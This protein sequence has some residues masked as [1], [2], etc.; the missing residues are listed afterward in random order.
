MTRVAPEPFVGRAAELAKLRDAFTRCRSGEGS[1][2]VVLA[3]AGG[4]KTRLVETFAEE[5]KASGATIA[6]GRSVEDASVGYWPWR[7]VFRRLEIPLSLPDA[8]A[9]AGSDERAAQRLQVA[10]DALTAL[11]SIMQ[12]G[13]IA[14][15]LEDLHWA[16]EPSLHLLRLLAPEIAAMP[17][18]ILATGRDPEPGTPFESTLGSIVGRPAVIVIRLPALTLAEV[19]AYVGEAPEGKRAAWVHSQS[20]G[21]ALYVRELCRLLPSEP[22]GPDD[23]LPP[24]PVEIRAVIAGRLAQLDEP[25][26]AVVRA[27]TVL[28]DE[29]E[30]RLLEAVHGAPVAEAVDAAVRRAILAH[31]PETPGRARFVHGLVRSALYVELPSALRV[32][33]HRRAAEF[34]EREG[35][36]EREEQAGA[37]ARH[38]LRGASSAADRTRAVER[39]RGAARISVRQ[40]AFE[41]AARLLRSASGAAALAPMEPAEAAEVEVELATAEFHA[42]LVRRAVETSRRAVDLA[43]EAR[44]PDLAAT[45]ALVVSGVGVETLAMLLPIKERAL[46]LLP[47]GPS[48]LRVRL[49][50]QVASFRAE[51]G[52]MEEAEPASRAALAEAE[53]LADPDALV[54]AIRAR[55]FVCSGPDGVAERQ[56]LASLMIELGRDPTRAFAA[57]WGRLWRIDAALQLGEMAEVHAELTELATVVERLDRPMARWHLLFVRAGLAV[58]A[59]RFDE[60]ERLAHDARRLGGRLEHVSFVG[61]TYVMTGEIERLRGVGNETAER[62]PIVQEFGHPVARLTIASNAVAF[63]DIETARRLYEQVRPFIPGLARDGLWLP[64]M[65]FFAETAC[66]LTDV[67]GAALCYPALAP[68]GSQCHTGG[69]GTVVCRGSLSTVLGRMAALLGRAEDAERHYAAAEATNRRMGALP[70]LAETLLHWAELV[71]DSDPLRARA[72]A[73]E[74]GA[75]AAR[76]GME[77]V[78]RATGALLE[79]VRRWRVGA[80]PLTRREREVAALVAE[81]R[82]N[83]EIAEHF[84]LSERTVETHVSRILTK[85]QLTSRTQL[86]AWVLARH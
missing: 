80:D 54:E 83:R 2:A 29:F 39:L 28:G 45:A 5:C 31:D 62:A 52:A 57:L 84:V 71:E 56:R 4:G 26:A 30:L 69:A 59:G 23:W 27:A 47:P 40:F 7:Q 17:M 18:M 74:A 63:G 67:D 11:S 34:L 35:A 76:L 51:L 21:N 19:A 8:D 41:E 3:E 24:L 10:D 58:T 79:R 32:E 86:A 25:E 64:T 14:V 38:W 82:S 72:L 20:A 77:V 44:R 61:L 66:D 60:A 33:L 42:G 9:T 1:M 85:L 48:A 16:D 53:R 81:G 13:P 55:H 65:S 68:Y 22:M 43:Q 75:I 37:L 12:T 73:Q 50:A 15:V 70:Y 46:A 49:E 36:A 78:A 6:W